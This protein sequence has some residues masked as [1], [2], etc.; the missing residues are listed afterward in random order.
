MKQQEVN[1]I[2][3]CFLEYSN[4]ICLHITC[5]LPLSSMMLISYIMFMMSGLGVLILLT[6]KIQKHI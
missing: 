1:I 2:K 6:E 4:K 3:K 5:T